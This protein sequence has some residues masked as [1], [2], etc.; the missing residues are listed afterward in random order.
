MDCGRVIDFKDGKAGFVR[1][2]LEA[3]RIAKLIHANRN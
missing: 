3:K 1:M 2:E